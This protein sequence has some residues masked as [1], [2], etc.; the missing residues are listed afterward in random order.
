MGHLRVGRDRDRQSVLRRRK[1]PGALEV[2]DQGE[3]GG[4][5]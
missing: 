2:G 5:E 3:R 1:K 4:R